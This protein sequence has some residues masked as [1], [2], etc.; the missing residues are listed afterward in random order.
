MANIKL[1]RRS[2]PQTAKSIKEIT[3]PYE[4]VDSNKD[5]RFYG[6]I[7]KIETS[8]LTIITPV[9]Q[10][11]YVSSVGSGYV[12]PAINL[13]EDIIIDLEKDKAFAI[14]VQL[15]FQSS[16]SE[17]YIFQKFDTDFEITEREEIVDGYTTTIEVLISGVISEN[18]TIPVVF[19]SEQLVPITVVDTDDSKVIVTVNDTV[20]KNDQ[21]VRFVRGRNVT[22]SA[23]PVNPSSI[24]M[25][26]LDIE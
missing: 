10:L 23:E 14:I 22:I 16:E 24:K 17:R 4:V 20:I 8:R 25:V 18:I 12:N 9:G 15:E 6:S 5:C 2:T 13:G 1:V 7:S 19:E 26:I 11:Q 3:S 21:T